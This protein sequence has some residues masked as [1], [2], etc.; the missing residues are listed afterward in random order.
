MGRLKPDPEFADELR[1]IAVRLQS[2]WGQNGSIKETAKEYGIG[3]STLSRVQEGT[4]GDGTG[5]YL[6]TLLRLAD[7]LGIAVQDL[8]PPR[9]KL[10]RTL[11]DIVE[12]LDPPARR[13]LLAHAR[14]LLAT[15]KAGE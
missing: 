5:P 4:L 3:V 2:L 6:L 14:F 15:Q 13:D 7:I 9:E 8:F 12:Q 10:R 11:F 1:D